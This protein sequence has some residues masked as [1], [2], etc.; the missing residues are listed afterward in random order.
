M[1]TSLA[2][3]LLI[4]TDAVKSAA[5]LAVAVGD[6]QSGVDAARKDDRSPVTVADFGVQIL[7]HAALRE[8][9]PSDPIVSEEDEGELLKPGNESMLEEVARQ[10]SAVRPDLH[11]RD[12]PSLIAGGGHP[13]GASGRFWCLDPVDGTKGFLR[14]DQYAIALALIQDGRP[15]LGVLGC[16]RLDGGT[17]YW[18]AQ[19][20]AGCS[21]LDG[22]NRRSIRV[23]YRGQAAEA[24]FCESFES[25]HSAHGASARVIDRLGSKAEP[26]RM[27]SQ[28]KYAVVA[29]GAGDIYLRLP[30]RG[31]YQERIWDHAAGAFIVEQVGGRVTDIYGRSLDFSKGRTLAANKGVV[32]TNGLLHDRAIDAVRHVLGL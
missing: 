12:L 14:G 7:V 17:L 30:T 22:G 15:V 4:A 3:E 11:P 5:R 27:D 2:H 31:D 26:R 23:S 19:G 32:A 1:D 24:V 16:P 25:G 9:F 10:V 13:G 29:C 6:G 20:T 8:V 28:A 18:A 21:D